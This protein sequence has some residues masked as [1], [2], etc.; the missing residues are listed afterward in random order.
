M[1]RSLPFEDLTSDGEV[2]RLALQHLERV[3]DLESEH[4]VIKELLTS[5]LAH[6]HR[7]L[8]QAG[9]EKAFLLVE[10]C[11]RI[12][13]DHSQALNSVAWQIV[14]ID[15]KSPS[16][17][18][19]ALS[20]AKKA[21]E[22]D[23]T[24]SGLLN[25]LGVAHYRNGNWRQAI[26]ALNKSLDTNTH[27]SFDG[28]FLAMAHWQLDEKDIAQEWFDKAKKWMDENDSKNAELIRF[29]AEAEALMG[30]DGDDDSPD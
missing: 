1:L 11:L 20:L 9:R 17:Y 22:I 14:A 27:L 15:G 30:S 18:E 7:L 6:V 21:A 19:L 28:F 13:G 4:P 29:R 26:D 16:V 3:R 10:F 8:D 25:T 24:S 2:S 12:S 23:P 5:I